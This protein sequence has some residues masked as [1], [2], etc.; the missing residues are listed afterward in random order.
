[1]Q[2]ISLVAPVKGTQI[3][4]EKVP[5]PVFSERM[6]GDGVAFDPE[7]D[8]LFAPISGTVT[9][10]FPTQHAFQLKSSGGLEA[11]VHIGI[12][13]VDLN[14]KGF[15]LTLSEGQT[16]TAGEVIGRVDFA[17]VRSQGLLPITM[18]VFPDAG[19]LSIIIE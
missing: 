19:E 2:K 16:V 15:A 11:L 8:T 9:A 10:I 14:G 4:L 17:Y 12:D 1:M 5:D 7:E 13:T 18:V 6:M 3:A